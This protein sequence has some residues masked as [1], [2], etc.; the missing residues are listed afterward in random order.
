MAEVVLELLPDSLGRILGVIPQAILDRA[1]IRYE[2]GHLHAVRSSRDD[3]RQHGEMTG[4]EERMFLG[5]SPLVFQL[6]DG[7]DQVNALVD[8][9]DGNLGSQASGPKGLSPGGSVA[10][11]P[12]YGHTDPPQ[13]RRDRHH[14]QGVGW[15]RRF[16]DHRGVG[17]IATLGQIA[18]A[19][20]GAVHILFARGGGESQVPL[21]LEDPPTGPL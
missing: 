11:F 14:S 15:R 19:D 12:F 2:E 6:A 8:G 10:G 13:A 20:G 18:G 7:V 1:V 4:F 17:S 21:E 9:I 3:A 16:R 5:Q